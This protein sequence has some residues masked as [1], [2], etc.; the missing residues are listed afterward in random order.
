MAA[1][2]RTLP[3]GPQCGMP[4]SKRKS[5]R[6]TGSKKKA[7]R[8]AP[9]GTVL[10]FEKYADEE[11]GCISMDG[12]VKLAEELDI[13]PSTDTKLLVLC[14]RLGA[15]KP[16]MLQKSEWVLITTAAVKDHPRN[17]RSSKHVKNCLPMA[18]PRSFAALASSTLFVAKTLLAE[19]SKC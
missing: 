14:W 17:R 10:N 1:D 4:P 3:P 19:R 13:D 16:G 2:P 15:S 12:L 9:P 7:A 11:E 8:T 6:S 18:P 5:G